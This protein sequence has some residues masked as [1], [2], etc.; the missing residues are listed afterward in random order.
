MG[1]MVA[2][3]NKDLIYAT[4]IKF[5]WR[6]HKTVDTICSFFVFLTLRLRTHLPVW[7]IFFLSLNTFKKRACHVI[8]NLSLRKSSRWKHLDY[9]S[10]MPYCCPQRCVLLRYSKV[11]VKANVK[12][13]L[14]D[15]AF[16][17]IISVFLWVEVLE[18]V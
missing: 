4:K 18:K 12:T 11:R 8:V 1:L 17:V 16:S 13:A 5:I 2:I 3:S 14:C 9:F 7:F 15:A 6:S 10:I